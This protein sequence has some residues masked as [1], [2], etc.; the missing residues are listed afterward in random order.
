MDCIELN[1]GIA[2]SVLGLCDKKFV[3]IKI[4]AGF[5]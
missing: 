1:A 2:M 4:D 3:K 5:S